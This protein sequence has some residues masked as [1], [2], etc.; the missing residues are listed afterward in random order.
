[1]T[2]HEVNSAACPVIAPKPAEMPRRTAAVATPSDKIHP[3]HLDRVAVVYVRQSSPHQVLEHRESRERQYALADRAVQLGWS[4]DRVLVIDEDQGHSGKQ[5]DNRSGFQR[6]LVEV[7]LDHVGLIL[8]LEM[9][10]LTRSNK[11]WHHL[12]EVCAVFRTALADSDGVYDPNDPNDRM[13]L[14][15]KGMISEVEL[16]TLRNRLTQGI[17]HKARRGEFFTVVPIG[18]VRLPDD[19]LALDPDEQV[20]SVVRL[21]FEKFQELGSASAVLTWDWP[22]SARWCIWPVAHARPPDIPQR[23][24]RRIARTFEYPKSDRGTQHENRPN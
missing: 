5:A 10:R 19:K 8:N 15:L 6:L 9:S 16:H 22:C 24:S 12:L 17:L 23:I 4:A 21:I 20:Q 3:Y 1:M 7:G 14:G 11:D 13:L 18:Y 2:R